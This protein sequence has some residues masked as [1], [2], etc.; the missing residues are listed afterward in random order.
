MQNSYNR[1]FLPFGT[2]PYSSYW[3]L[4]SKEIFVVALQEN[5]KGG[6]ENFYWCPILRSEG[7]GAGTK[8]L[9]HFSL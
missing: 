5:S 6:R 1:V 2:F 3:L 4:V 8:E 7:E 9:A